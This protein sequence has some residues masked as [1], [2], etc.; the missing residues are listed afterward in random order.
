MQEKLMEVD[1]EEKELKKEHLQAQTEIEKH[2]LLLVRMKVLEKEIEMRNKNNTEM[3]D[4]LDDM[5]NK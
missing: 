3:N 5:F 1:V 4:K 2:N